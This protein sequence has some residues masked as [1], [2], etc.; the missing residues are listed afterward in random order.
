MEV[1]P[2]HQAKSRLSQLIKRA[3]NGETIL[4]GA[5]GQAEAKLVAATAETKCKKR[6][7]VLTS[8]LK[9]PDD[10]DAP[11]DNDVLIELEGR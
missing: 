6:I 3:A 1:I 9:V 8:K 10:F 7:G 5:G 4:I 2:V 11:L